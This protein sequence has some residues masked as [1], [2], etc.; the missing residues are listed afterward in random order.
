M[1]SW[2][3][4]VLSFLLLLVICMSSLKKCLFRFLAQFLIGVFTFVIIFI[5][6]YWLVRVPLY[7]WVL[8]AYQLYDLHIF[9]SF[10]Y[11]AFSLL[12]ISFG[13]QNFLVLYSPAHLFWFFFLFAYA[14]G[15]VSRKLLPR[16]IL[17]RFPPV[18]SSRSLVVLD[19]L[20]KS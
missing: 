19:N 13:E 16:P 5:F 14:L 6:C 1:K 4:L 10:L 9:F 18:F 3:H 15:V 17:Q 12:I 8:N 11:V 20:F 7:T 2:V